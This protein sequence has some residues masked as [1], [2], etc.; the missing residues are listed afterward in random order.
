[1]HMLFHHLD[2]ILQQLPASWTRFTAWIEQFPAS[3]T[4]S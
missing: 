4:H 1:M 2:P 3:N